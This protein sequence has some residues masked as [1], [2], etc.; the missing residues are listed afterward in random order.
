MPPP[1]C[2][3]CGLW[4]LWRRIQPRPRSYGLPFVVMAAMAS[5]DWRFSTRLP[6]RVPPLQCRA[7]SRHRPPRRLASRIRRPPAYGLDELRSDLELFVFLLGGSDGEDL[8][9]ATVEE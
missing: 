6:R 2:P 4:S 1:K 9:G 5:T 7:T 8:F 3:T